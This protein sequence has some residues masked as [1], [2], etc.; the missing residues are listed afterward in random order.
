M[1]VTIFSVMVVLLLLG[2]LFLGQ[3]LLLRFSG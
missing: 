2:R 3:L 1:A